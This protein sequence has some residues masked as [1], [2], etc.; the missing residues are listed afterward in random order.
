MKKLT[1]WKQGF[2]AAINDVG[3]GGLQKRVAETVRKIQ[4]ART[5]RQ[6]EDMGGDV[7]TPFRVGSHFPL[8]AVALLAS[9]AFTV[10]APTQPIDEALD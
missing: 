3:R 9:L 8:A 4:R 10:V 7:A 1:G 2:A 5:G 6:T